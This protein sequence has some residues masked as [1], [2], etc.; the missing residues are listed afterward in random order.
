MDSG[1]TP[2]AEAQTHNGII[3]H[4]TESPAVLW[5]EPWS[6]VST[7]DVIAFLT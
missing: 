2:S 5:I 4:Q 3:S 6:E 1:A 7:A